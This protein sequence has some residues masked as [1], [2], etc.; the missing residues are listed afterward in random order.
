M[1]EP[2]ERRRGLTEDDRL[3]IAK[4]IFDALCAKFPEKYVALVQPRGD[5]T[6]LIEA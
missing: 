6:P 1:T 3:E 2:T 5:P 4:R